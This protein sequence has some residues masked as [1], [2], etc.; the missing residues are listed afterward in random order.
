M[1][2]H[3]DTYIHICTHT[4]T[5][6]H[7]CIIVVY[8]YTCMCTRTCMHMYADRH[9]HVHVSRYACRYVYT[10]KNMDAYFT[11]THVRIFVTNLAEPSSAIVCCCTCI[12]DFLFK[13]R[14]S[15]TQLQLSQH[16][17]FSMKSPHGQIFKG[18]A[19]P[20]AILAGAALPGWLRHP[21]SFLSTVW[22]APATLEVKR[23]SSVR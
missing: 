10:Y 19:I 2:I 4:Q 13:L 15:P 14:F 22:R 17:L 23:S 12:G 6:E 16:L 20:L 21:Q 1:H 9:S 3:I 8:K 18:C 5:Y 7:I 11:Y